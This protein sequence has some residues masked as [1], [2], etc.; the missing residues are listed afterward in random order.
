MGYIFMV[1]LYRVSF[2]VQPLVS[3]LL[4]VF[5]FFVLVVL[6]SKIESFGWGLSFDFPVFYMI[7]VKL[8]SGFQNNKLSS[9]NLVWVPWVFLS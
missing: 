1:S 6:L 3:I 7:V 9:F 8:E 2:S 5:I 4:L